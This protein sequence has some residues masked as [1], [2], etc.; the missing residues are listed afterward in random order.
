[1]LIAQVISDNWQAEDTNSH[2]LAIDRDL[3]TKPR[4]QLCHLLEQRAKVYTHG[5][6]VR[7]VNV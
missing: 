2:L 7:Q 6:G 5:F 4:P 1:M 3:E